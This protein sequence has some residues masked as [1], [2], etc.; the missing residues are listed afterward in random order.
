MPDWKSNPEPIKLCPFCGGRD[1]EVM[2]REYE[3]VG[4]HD[5][6]FVICTN[7]GAQGPEQLLDK[8]ASAQQIEDAAKNAVKGWN[9]VHERPGYRQRL[10]Q[11][12]QT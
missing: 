9:K 3:T 1:I 10:T 8:N 7:C 5:T 12:N 6:C 4:V 11:G 2:T